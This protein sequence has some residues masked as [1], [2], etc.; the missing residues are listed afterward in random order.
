MTYNTTDF[1]ELLAEITTEAERIKSDMNI[2]DFDR[3][4]LIATYNSLTTVLLKLQ[5]I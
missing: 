2:Y 4:E 5:A 3:A 1:D